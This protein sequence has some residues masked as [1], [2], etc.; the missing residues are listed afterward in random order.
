VPGLQILL[1]HLFYLYAAFQ[2]HTFTS[3][4]PTIFACAFALFN[5]Y[6]D[7]TF[8]TMAD[9]SAPVGTPMT[10]LVGRHNYK[11]WAQEFEMA[12]G[13]R[14]FWNLFTGEEQLK[15]APDPAHYQAEMGKAKSAFM[16]SY[17]HH[18]Y[19]SD[20]W[21]WEDQRGRINDAVTF[22][23]ESMQP[24]VGGEV[25]RH[26]QSRGSRTTILPNDLWLAARDLY[27]EQ[28]E[29][30]PTFTPAITP[31]PTPTHAPTLTSTFTPTPTPTAAQAQAQAQAPAPAPTPAEAPAARAPKT[32]IGIAFRNM[33]D[34]HL[35][36]CASMRDFFHRLH[37]LRDAL[38]AAGAPYTDE[39]C[40]LKILM[41]LTPRYAPPVIADLT[42]NMLADM[43]L[44]QMV[45]Y[46][47]AWEEEMEQRDRDR[48]VG[49]GA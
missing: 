11:T 28:E 25:W 22:M 10:P 32:A 44:T 1:F 16:A 5:L 46:F 18:R 19:E 40:K 9:P 2:H 23:M 12:A 3:F 39:Q 21:E 14:G 48:G 13:H 20:V 26:A 8:R 15:H 31:T 42:L 29:H 38:W 41:S 30:T 24:K 43:R 35:Q 37:V 4:S 34:L 27:D 45:D 7:A 6:Q 36:H 47:L 33:N 49:V 17:W